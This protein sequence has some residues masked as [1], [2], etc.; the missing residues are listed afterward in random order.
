MG[1]EE[2]EVGRDTLGFDVL[3]LLATLSRTPVT[4]GLL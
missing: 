3:L 2:A 1:F 4:D